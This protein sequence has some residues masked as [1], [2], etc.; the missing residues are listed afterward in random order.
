MH[1]GHRHIVTL[2]LIGCMI[3]LD[4]TLY[5]QQQRFPV[6]ANLMVLPPYSTQYNSYLSPTSNKMRAVVTLLDFNEPSVDVR[7]SI[8]V[9]GPDFKAQTRASYLPRN[10]I[11]LIPGVPSII[12]GAQ[13]VEYFESQNL[14]FFGISRQQFVT[15]GRFPEGLYTFSLVVKEFRSDKVL[16]QVAMGTAWLKLNDQPTLQTPRIGEVIAISGPQNIF[17]QWQL[18][19]SASA[20]TP[21]TP[22]YKFFLYELINQAG[23]PIYALENGNTIPVFES[24]EQFSNTFNYTLANPT[25]DVGKKYMWRVQA[26]DPTG[27]NIFRDNGF[28]PN[29]WFYYGYPEGGSIV[30]K[31]PETGY[32]F[33]ADEPQFLKFGAPDN[34]LNGQQIEYRLKIVELESEEDDPELAVE[35]GTAWF[36]QKTPPTRS[37]SDYTLDV[38]K[39]FDREQPYAW[40]VLAYTG[41]QEIAASEPWVFKGPSL[42][43]KFRA[44]IHTVYVTEI[45]EKDLNNLS[46]KG[47]VKIYETDTDST[48]TEISFSGLSIEDVSGRYVLKEGV[49]ESD[50]AS[51]LEFELAPRNELNGVIYFYPTKVRLDK[52]ELS[53][54]GYAEY[55]FPHPVNGGAEA[56]MLATEEGWMN[57]D[58]YKPYGELTLGKE[59][60]VDL[61]EPFD[62]S[63]QFAESSQIQLFY[64]EYELKLDGNMLLSDKVESVD[65]NRIG[66]PFRRAEQLYYLEEERV[67]L[68]GDVKIIANTNASFNSLDYVIDLSEKRSPRGVEGDEW[69]GIYFNEFDVILQTDLDQNGQLL[70]D[71][72]L[73]ENVNQNASRDTKAWIDGQGLDFAWEEDLRGVEI[74]RFN[75]FPAKL[76]QVSIEVENSA[77]KRGAFEG[78][79]VVHAIDPTRDLPFIVPADQN[80]FKPGYLTESLDNSTFAFNPYGGENKVEVTIRRAVFKNNDHLSLTADFNIPKFGIKINGI[81][82]F[83]LY[84]DY[85]IGFGERNGATNVSSRPQGEYDG[86][87]FSL[88]ELGASLTA[89]NYVFSYN[90]E[91][92]MGPGFEGP[93]LAFHS[94]T[95]AEGGAENAS[96]V[97]PIRPEIYVPE[98]PANQNPKELLVD[99]LRIT[100]ENNQIY[101]TAGVEVQKG[102]PTYGTHYRGELEGEL[103]VPARFALGGN[104]IYGS[105]PHE[106]FY[107]DAFYVDE[108]GIGITVY[109]N[110]NLVGMEGWVYKGMSVKVT[111]GEEGKE[112]AELVLDRNNDFGFNLFGQF[113]DQASF[114]ANYQLD[115]TLAYNSNTGDVTIGGDISMINMNVRDPSAMAGVSNQVKQEVAQEAAKQVLEALGGIDETVSVEGVDVR[116]KLDERSGS[117]GVSSGGY[118][119][120]GTIDIGGTPSATV[121]LEGGGVAVTLKGDVRDAASVSFGS[122]EL[123]STIDYRPNAGGS[124]AMQHSDFTL[125]ADVNVGNQSGDMLFEGGGITNRIKANMS[126]K[127]GTIV[128]DDGSRSLEVDGQLDQ[129]KAGFA[130]DSGD[131]VIVEVDADGKSKSGQSSIFYEGR[132]GNIELGLGFNQQSGNGKLDYK[133]NDLELHAEA[134]QQGSMNVE[135]LWD[136]N[137][138]KLTGAANDGGSLDVKLDQQELQSW[139]KLDGQGGLSFKNPEY[140]INISGNP[141]TNAGALSFEMADL[142]IAGAMDPAAQTANIDLLVE[143]NTVIGN[144]SRDVQTLEVKTDQVTLNALHN[145]D[146][147]GLSLTQGQD[148]FSVGGDPANSKGFARLVQGGNEIYIQADQP[149]S[150]GAI[151]FK[152]DNILANATVNDQ[153][154]E[155]AF[156]RDDV[157]FA[158]THHTDSIYASANIQGNAVE[159]SLKGS[160]EI[161]LSGSLEGVDFSGLANQSDKK[162]LFNLK[163]PDHTISSNVLPDS[164]FFS[165]EGNDLGLSGAMHQAG[166]IA[167]ALDKD[168]IK[169]ELQGGKTADVQE[170]YFQKDQ[171][172][173]NVTLNKAQQSGKLEV[174]QIG[175]NAD[176]AFTN[177]AQ[178]LGIKQGSDSIRL[179]H[180]GEG[181]G[182][183]AMAYG[184]TQ[185]TIAANTNEGTGTLS[186][187]NP[188]VVLD[189]KA[190]ANDPSGSFTF[191]QASIAA[192]GQYTDTR[193]ALR[194][195]NAEDYIRMIKDGPAVDGGIRYG[196]DSLALVYQPAEQ[197]GRVNLAYGTNTIN[198]DLNVPN[199]R[200][201]FAMALDGFACNFDVAI[202]KTKFNYNLS[203]DCNI[204]LDLGYDLEANIPAIAFDVPALGFELGTLPSI[205]F[206]FRLGAFNLDF[207]AGYALSVEL[208]NFSLS[209]PQLNGLEGF[210]LGQLEGLMINGAAFDVNMDGLDLSGFDLDAGIGVIGLD[211]LAGFPLAL[212]LS[213]QSILL[214]FDNQLAININAEGWGLN[215]PGEYDLSLDMGFNGQLGQMNFKVPEL[216]GFNISP[217]A[218]SILDGSLPL[219]TVSLESFAFAFDGFELGISPKLASF[220]IPDVIGADFGLDGFNL[221]LATDFTA[222]FD[223]NTGLKLG[224]ED[225]EANLGPDIGSVNIDD[226]GINLPDG[227]SGFELDWDNKLVGFA[228]EGLSIDV[229]GYNLGL[230]ADQLQLG[231]NGD[232]IALN[233]DGT[234][235][236]NIGDFD[237]GIAP[238]EGFDFTSPDFNMGLNTDGL[239][240][241][242]GEIKLDLNLDQQLSLSGLG[243]H[244]FSMS[245]LGFGYAFDDINLDFDINESLSFSGLDLDIALNPIEGIDMKYGDYGIRIGVDA[246]LDLSLGSLNK[247]SINPDLVDFK[248]DEFNMGFGI[249]RNLY[250]NF[251]PYAFELNAEA[252]AIDFED[253][254]LGIGLDQSLYFTKGPDINLNIAPGTF[255][256]EMAD[257]SLGFDANVLQ[258]TS[259]DLS[260]STDDLTLDIGDYTMGLTKVGDIPAIR[261]WNPG[262]ID[263]SLDINQLGRFTMGGLDLQLSPELLFDL[264]YDQRL[265]LFGSYE[266]L[267]LGWDDYQIKIGLDTLIDFNLDPCKIMF[268]LQDPTGKI[269]NFQPGLYS[270]C[271]EYLLSAN[272]GGIR[273]QQG[274]DQMKRSFTINPTMQQF[275]YDEFE[276]DRF[277]GTLRM[278]DGYKYK[279][280]YLRPD[281]GFGGGIGRVTS[282]NDLHAELSMPDMQLIGLRTDEENK[283]EGMIN[284]VSSGSVP[285][286]LSDSYKNNLDGYFLYTGSFPPDLRGKA[287][288]ELLGISLASTSEEGENLEESPEIKTNEPKHIGTIADKAGGFLRGDFKLWKTGNQSIMTGNVKG[289]K[290]VTVEGAYDFRASPDAW[291]LK[292]GTLNQPITISMS[293]ASI[294]G[295]LWLDQE[296]VDIGFSSGASYKQSYDFKAWGVGFGFKA[297][298][299]YNVS[300]AFKGL[301][302]SNGVE[303]QRF[304]VNASAGAKL[305]GEVCWVLDCSNFNIAGV[306]LSGELSGSLNEGKVSGGLTGRVTILGEDTGDFTLN[307]SADL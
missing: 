256:F 88:V 236:A 278:G 163:L 65:G 263:I 292:M 123:T 158:V 251:D 272:L 125:D 252:L 261:F 39:P 205:P 48:L 298:A 106:F 218:L 45:E 247:L 12:E 152:Y 192:S 20:G 259:P 26:T 268:L 297:S 305:D 194:V 71:E 244:S 157:S 77:L 16:S 210:T 59:V 89:G 283:I 183:A 41:Q 271:D 288:E 207:D 33:A 95:P 277:K 108:Q 228:P 235:D 204:G 216:A 55:P 281:D 76:N 110:V 175:V 189:I 225:F 75:D 27:Q 156:S 185:V 105:D 99:K 240:A 153:T 154:K 1:L 14:D 209:L 243:A 103:K 190:A 64:D 114:G 169:A 198:G 6:Q 241:G 98:R 160:D 69:K 137:E 161:R 293:S 9:E 111:E 287:L 83:N 28:S 212:N 30:L 299:Y 176:A 54:G 100:Y 181:V 217:G 193:Q 37:T 231:F 84:G 203:D 118:S 128:F 167:L 61:L 13:W 230:L 296:S 141:N 173:I 266:M 285:G 264:N 18:N 40:Q 132:N 92:N 119:G 130:F 38:K 162:G 138:I 131:G 148:I 245:P 107:M 149:Q 177:T 34:L 139:M 78:S 174:E 233:F 122:S 267:K 294:D 159:A 49:I 276:L 112:N 85:Y 136:N 262:E 7:F 51:G 226:I 32:S 238:L 134:S 280:N 227:Y 143:G 151:V 15:N 269:P 135:G 179:N 290:L 191:E 232:L 80:G 70:L 279:L 91:V 96:A 101:F 58:R 44:G 121:A 57:F 42:I 117:L 265:N 254:S 93:T 68:D 46:G 219:I 208:P 73:E 171:D 304:S 274:I 22:S 186:L 113:I 172:L 182:N 79:I 146:S 239:Y 242:L 126:S 229:D 5:A 82:D 282:N 8:A 300:G 109:P 3:I 155:V 43:D 275:D 195:N 164:A 222:G 257:Y 201:A 145:A 52:E 289:Q 2:L 270:V 224:W 17:F 86:M 249:D 25:L 206:K 234:L 286:T 72:E 116:V 302:G 303:F 60:S 74:A 104:L 144:V 62:F 178:S 284:K 165:Y 150:S 94:L 196:S 67:P 19:N 47:K 246:D 291:S 202:D 11:T 23:D 24:P 120:L 56:P 129:Q 170:F 36:E 211:Q 215:L 214:D 260:F 248:F 81:R 87:K 97:N 142:K 255:G 31:T 21:F 127:E 253:L 140:A 90:T 115:G 66:V 168:N 258:F 53:I 4:L 124:F 188:D 306:D 199:Y 29:G 147:T 63:L 237:L 200:A 223:I 35:T 187:A 213:A 10:P 301:Y 133:D 197:S 295:Y 184:D 102:H 221:S 307:I 166:N 273:F 220:Q 250:F 180:E 50:I